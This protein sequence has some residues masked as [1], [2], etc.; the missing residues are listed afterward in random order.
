MSAQL[1]VNTDNYIM[2]SLKPT[3]TVVS[4]LVTCKSY[5]KY[6][7]KHVEFDKCVFINS[8]MTHEC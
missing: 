2:E 8:D 7:F 1:G 3:L 5:A 6:I 4:D